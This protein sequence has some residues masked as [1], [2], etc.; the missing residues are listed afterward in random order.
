LTELIPQR[1][2]RVCVRA[3]TRP[4]SPYPS[5]RNRHGPLSQHAQCTV[6]IRRPNQPPHT[7]TDQP[8]YPQNPQNQPP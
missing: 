8:K 2:G 6:T 1:H 3:V 7:T 5:R 4:S